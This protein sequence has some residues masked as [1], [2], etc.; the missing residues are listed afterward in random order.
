MSNQERDHVFRRAAVAL[1]GPE[2]AARWLD[3]PNR[4]LGGIR[5]AE[6]LGTTDGARRVE[7]IL[8]RIEHGV[9]S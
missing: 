5:P 9:Y 3:H 4:A 6:C 1:G 2:K 7:R 8:G